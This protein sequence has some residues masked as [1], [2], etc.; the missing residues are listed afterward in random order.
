MIKTFV[1]ILASL[2]LYMAPAQKVA[3]FSWLEGVWTI[4]T[5]RYTIQERWYQ[6]NDSTMQGQSVLIKPTG[7]TIPQESLEISY[8]AGDWYYISKVIG[9]NNNQAVRFKIVYHK[10]LEFI[11]ENPLHDFP[12]RIQYRKINQQLWASIEGKKNGKYGKQNFDFMHQEVTP[13]K[14]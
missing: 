1:T 8:T 5:D 3:T 9:Q 7:D 10:N 4:R 13:E 2:S 6:L 11:S 14:Q 12:Q